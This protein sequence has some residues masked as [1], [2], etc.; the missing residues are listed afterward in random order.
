[1]AVD[2]FVAGEP[3]LDG[4]DVGDAHVDQH[5]DQHIKGAM[6]LPFNLFSRCPVLSVPSGLAANGVPTGVQVVGRTYDDVT[7]YRVASALEAALVGHG[8]G[9]GAPSWWPPVQR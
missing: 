2:G 8:V 7:A 9:F 1:M 3:Y 5:L 4:I 6:T